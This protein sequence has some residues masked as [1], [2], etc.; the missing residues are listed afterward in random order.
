MLFWKVCMRAFLCAIDETVWDSLENGYVRPTTAK[1]ECDKAA[2]ALANT[3][4]KDINAIFCGVSTDEF[5]RIS[6]MMTAKEARIIL[7]TTYEATK[8]V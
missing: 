3:N 4:N 2:L 7:K 1:S 5:H 6:H 8:K